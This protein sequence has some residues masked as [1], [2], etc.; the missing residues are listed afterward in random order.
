MLKDFLKKY[1]AEYGLT[2]TDLAGRLSVSQNA[3]SQYES[4][5]RNPPV[6]KIADIARVL[7]CSV[8]D[9]VSD[10]DTRQEGSQYETE[11]H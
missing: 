9:L 2:Q 3:I 11:H 6:S 4:G 5:K 8:G 1:R 10:T 7:G